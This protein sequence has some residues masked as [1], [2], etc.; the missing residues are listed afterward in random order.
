[1]RSMT[2]FGRSERSESGVSVAVQVSSVNRKNLDIIC[3]LPKEFQ[4]LERKVTDRARER[5]GRGRLQFSVEI[6]DER[7]ELGGLPSDAQIDAGVAR[8]KRLAERYGGSGEIDAR[9]IVNLA[10]L[11]EAEASVLP[12][13]MVE[14][15]LLDCSKSA[16]EDL[17]GMREREGEA[18]RGDLKSRCRKM[19]DTVEAVRKFAPEM[20]AKHRE[21]LYSRLEQAGLELDVSDERVLKEIA[22][23]A[24][25]SDVSEELTRLKSHLEQFS[26]SLEKD[27]PVG[28]SLEFIIQEIAREINTIGSKSCSIDISKCSLEMKNELERIREQVANVE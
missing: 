16:L 25:R 12:G 19:A 23:F 27:E 11:L 8:L 20:V 9:T 3:V 2:G 22:L 17:L 28:R 4:H 5:V 6:R 1:M 15:L 10:G 26:G 7:N 18:L 14:K 13:E 24:D 21:N